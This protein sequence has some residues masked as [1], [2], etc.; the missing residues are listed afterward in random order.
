MTPK[1]SAAVRPW[2]V[3]A[4]LVLLSLVPSVLG[5]ARVAGFAL[6]RATLPDHARLATQAPVVALH[7]VTAAAFALL[8]AFQFAAPLRGRPWHA[9]LGRVLAPAGAV[10]AASGI[11]LAVSL[12]DP[13]EHI[14][15][16][17]VLRVLAGVAT[18]VCLARGLFAAARG[19]YA[20]HGAWFTRA[21]AIFVA[22]G[23][24][25]FTLLPYVTLVDEARRVPAVASVLLAAG[26]GINLAVAELALRR[27][28]RRRGAGRPL[29]RTV[30]ALAALRAFAPTAA[31]ADER[32]AVVVATAGATEGSAAA[33]AARVLDAAAEAARDARVRD[34]VGAIA[35]GTTLVGAGVASWITPSSPGARDARD[36]VGGVFVGLGGVLALGGTLSVAAP[37]SIERLRVVY[38]PSLR[39]GGAPAAEAFRLVAR[40]LDERASAARLE[41]Y[42]TAVV[43]FSAGAAMAATGLALELDAKDDGLVW[44]GRGL[45]AASAGSVAIGV[46][47]LV[48]RSEDERLA[49]LFRAERGAVAR[50]SVG[51]RLSPRV[52][53]GSVGLGGSF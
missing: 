29:V 36:V 38:G 14:P 32:P 7:A 35:T 31:H 41:R 27:G 40:E 48:V 25:V 22:A 46:A 51:L 23:T 11:A 44:L 47:E 24:Q 6:G 42:V 30:V 8:G 33:H 17:R 53:F 19:G 43:S 50:R 12:P 21:Y 15:L 5:A 2:L 18:L 49:E 10:A 20:A 9:R 13:D 26:W 28:R 52:G 39:A 45:L 16:L 37:T 34:G 3:P 4:G 1:L